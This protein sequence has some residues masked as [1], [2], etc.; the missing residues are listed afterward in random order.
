MA[1]SAA[2]AQ[3]LHTPHPVILFY[4]NDVP[5]EQASGGPAPDTFPSHVELLCACRD[6][7]TCA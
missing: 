5:P 7:R 4:G 2:A 6:S 1:C 3:V